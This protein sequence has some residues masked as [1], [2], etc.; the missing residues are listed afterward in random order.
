MNKIY[1][2]I[3]NESL[4]AWVAAPEFTIAKAK[5]NSSNIGSGLKTHFGFAVTTLAAGIALAWGA[6]V[7]AAP[8]NI[9]LTGDDATKECSYLI[10]G[11][12]GKNCSTIQ[13]PDT[14]PGNNSI[15]IGNGA[16]ALAKGSISIGK[17]ATVATDA[18]EAIVIGEEAQAKA[19]R[20]VAIGYQAQTH[21]VGAV[22]IGSES[23]AKGDDAISLGKGAGKGSEG[24]RFTSIGGLS[25]KNSFG[26]HNIVIGSR[27]GNNIGTQDNP[28][29]QNIY[30]GLNAGNNSKASATG[31]PGYIN[32]KG[33]NI[34]IGNDAGTVVTGDLN[35]GIGQLA[36]KLTKGSANTAM[37]VQ[38]GLQVKG[39]RNVAIGAFA[40]GQVYGDF[41][42]AIGDSAG[43]GLLSSDEKRIKRS[44]SIGRS[45]KA[46]A[47]DAIALGTDAKAGIKDESETKRGAI[48]IGTGAEATARQSI[49]LGSAWRDDNKILEERH[50]K[51]TG[52]KSIAFGSGSQSEGSQSIAIG[53]NADAKDSYSLA[54]G[55]DVKAEKGESIAIGHGARST[56]AIQNV[57]IGSRSAVDGRLSLAIGQGA[58]ALTTEGRAT[59]VGAGTKASSQFA[60]AFGTFSAATAHGSSSIGP[61]STASAN[62]STALGYRSE[63]TAS[64][65]VTGG[66]TKFSNVDV[67]EGAIGVVSVGRSG[68]MYKG[69]PNTTPRRIINVQG[70]INDTDAVNVLQLQ[71]VYDELKNLYNSGGNGGTGNAGGQF[72]LSDENNK[73]F[74]QDLDTTAQIVGAGGITTTVIDAADGK[75]ALEVGLSHELTVG[76]TPSGKDGSIGVKGADG[77][78]GVAINGKDGSIGLTGPAGADGKSAEAVIRVKDGKPGIN[79]KD[80]ETMTRIVYTTPDGKEQQVATLSDGLKFAGNDGLIARELGQTLNIVG[81]AARADSTYSTTNVTT[82]A[83]GD[84]L[85]IQMAD[86]PKFSGE[87][88]ADG[89]ISITDH[90][91]VNPG[92][93]VNMGGNRITNVGPA[94]EDSDA[95]TLGQVK[96][97]TRNLSNGYN[98]LQRN[99]EKVRRDSNAGTAAAI[100]VA[101]LGQPYQPGQNMVSLGSGVWRGET[102]YA[103]G[104]STI[105]DN[106]KW[107][108]KGAVTGSGRGG[109][110]GSAS[111]NYAW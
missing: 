65:I 75:K 3:Y 17:K 83:S 94:K 86:S 37:G 103:L 11:E 106:G 25:G 73:E 79:G 39:S 110:G 55:D 60:T 57:A 9:I 54:I 28:S 107:L 14:T 98:A 26:D 16:Q 30:I 101:G 85:E 69:A 80:G 61:L 6:Q 82:V 97:L 70:G 59:A 68:S 88:Q 90:L 12:A 95:A 71:T 48:A 49:A 38:S 58:E 2:S 4:G 32:A 50:T 27:A 78:S 56:G 81:G 10:N 76:G 99:I 7:M 1:H 5:K 43:G 36:G 51:A 77:K 20:T 34:G 13:S 63:V 52:Y 62:F 53:I 29:P 64:D 23:Q 100:A 42:I 8:L 41:N 19:R 109:V 31:F 24:V 18:F 104:V 87:V 108:L 33:H 89:G 91:T 44:T 92:T 35:V 15:T 40:G 45:A 47:H 67:N 46:Y 72:G 74:K 84:K 66:K 96:E 93:T 21:T 105:S 111:I 22:A 102:G